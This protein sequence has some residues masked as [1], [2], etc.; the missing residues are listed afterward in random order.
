[1]EIA[2]DD[3]DDED[4]QSGLTALVVTVVELLVEALEGE[5]VRRMESGSLSDAEIER[6][7]SQLQ[8]LEAELDRLQADQDIEAA[9][10]EFKDDLDHVLRDAITQMS[11]AD[12]T[13]GFEPQHSADGDSG[14]GSA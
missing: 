10:D 13:P 5:A 4:L 9:V 3:H 7:G 8:A 14:G 11:E 6:L 12:S 2:L 1:M